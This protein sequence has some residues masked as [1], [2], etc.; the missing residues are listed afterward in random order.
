MRQH[1]PRLVTL[2]CLF[3]IL[4]VNA[5]ISM[6]IASFSGRKMMSDA[7][8]PETSRS[9]SSRL[10]A[11]VVKDSPYPTARGTTVDARQ[12]VAAGRPHIQAILISHVLLASPELA[13]EALTKLRSAEMEFGAL[14][15]SLSACY[16]TRDHDGLVGWV[17]VPGTTGTTS[18]TTRQRP[19]EDAIRLGDE[20]INAH[21]DAI[22]P[23]EA[24][25]TLLHL[26]TKPGDVVLIPS[27]RGHHLVQIRDVMADV[28]KMAFKKRRKQQQRDGWGSSGHDINFEELTYKMESMGCQMNTADS[29]RIEGQLMAL[30]IQP[31]DAATATKEPDI[32]I[33]NTCSIRDHAEQK[34]YSHLGPSRK[35]KR[36]G[37]T[38]HVIVVAGCVAQQEGRALLQHAPEID[39]VMGPQYANRLGD[40]LEDVMVNGN[41]VVATAATHIM[42]DSTKPRRGSKVA[43][44]VNVIYGC[45]ERCTFCIVPTTRG[46][47]QSRPVESI[48]KEVTELVQEQGYKEITLLGQNIDAYGRDMVPKRRFSDLIRAVGSIAGLE[49]LRFVTS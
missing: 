40:L 8:R 16:E 2:L 47:E 49:R 11:T 35:R 6:G 15:R 43:A 33:L 26:A 31:H 27:A 28:R 36:E 4:A 48:L 3:H 41:Q 10:A 46:V 9:V 5:F 37:D 22:F 1:S 44:W 32:V 20:D 24:R 45:N 19:I 25:D 30:G 13:A 18:A 14:A 7:D 17:N 38:K 29:E 12:I 21:L 42:E 39:L 34:V 23:R